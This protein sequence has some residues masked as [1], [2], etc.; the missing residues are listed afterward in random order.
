MHHEIVTENLR[1]PEQDQLDCQCADLARKARQ[2]LALLGYLL[3]P[4]LP[5]EPE[6]CGSG[7]KVHAVSYLAAMRAV[8]SHRLLHLDAAPRVV[9]DIT[10]H[11]AADLG[12]TCGHART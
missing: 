3:P 5:D 6:A 1:S 2:A 8:V 9:R 7:F 10:K 4:C 12:E 11:T